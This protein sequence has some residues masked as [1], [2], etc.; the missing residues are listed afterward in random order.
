MKQKQEGGRQKKNM[1]FYVYIWRK[2]FFF[3][4]SAA[5]KAHVFMFK[6][7]QKAK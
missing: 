5:T 4:Y 2:Y 7:I 3:F 6:Q 1:Q